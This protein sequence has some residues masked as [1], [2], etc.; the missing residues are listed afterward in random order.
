MPRAN[1][2]QQ[3]DGEAFAR[4]LRGARDNTKPTEDEDRR[5][6]LRIEV[7]TACLGLAGLLLA[8]RGVFSPL[9][10]IALGYYKYAKFA[11][12]AHHSLHGGWGRSRRGWFAQSI[13]RRFLDWLDWIFPQ[14]WIAEHNKV[15]HYALNEDADPDFVERNTR[16]IRNMEAPL[17]AKYFI[18]AVQA[19]IWKWWYYAS[20]TLKLLHKEKPGVP[21]RENFE[22]A[23][24]MTGLILE[25]IK[26]DPWYQALALDFLLRVMAPPFFLQFVAI[27]MGIG[28][29]CHGSFFCWFAFVNVIGAEVVTNVHAFATIVT[30]HAGDDMWWFPSG[31]KAD[32]PEF[33]L[34][35]IL[36]SAAYHAGTD[37]IDYFHGYLNYQAEHHAFPDLSPLHY[38]RLHP[39]F[40]LICAKHGV[41]YIQEPVWVRTKKT[42]D[43][44][45]GKSS[46]PRLSG[47]ATDHPEEW[48]VPN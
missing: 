37:S 43:I 7:W 47:D 27:P 14:A 8:A 3:F 42:A 32:T 15:H 11:I 48:M 21:S 38:Q 29:L 44:I 9:A 22:G 28:L 39:A 17:V 1:S 26:G 23:L 24:T 16:I 33:Y 12:L 6:L 36:G 30:N 35:A 34:R 18:V 20:N 46:H 13:T 19:M 10:M 40:K 5:H 2:K 4:D 45:V 31:C 25:A 41:P